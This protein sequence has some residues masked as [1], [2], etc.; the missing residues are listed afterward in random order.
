MIY[1]ENPYFFDELMFLE[2]EQNIKKKS[3][4]TTYHDT[5]GIQSKTRE[6]ETDT[7]GSESDQSSNKKTPS[8]AP[9]SSHIIPIGSFSQETSSLDITGLILLGL[10]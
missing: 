3:I 1:V 6:Y 10:L 7:T 8:Y 4:F 2:M 5:T 9:P